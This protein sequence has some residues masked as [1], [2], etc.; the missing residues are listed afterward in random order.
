MRD[1]L[2]N[3]A[4]F[5][6]EELDAILSEGHRK[7]ATAKELVFQAGNTF[8][9][10]WFI[11]SGMMRAFRIIDG[12]DYTFFFFTK[13]NFAVDYHSFLT[14]TPS[15]LFFEV[16]ADIEYMEFSRDTIFSLYD[17][18]PRF[19]R[20]GRIM[21]EQAFV[22][23]TER[24]RQLQGESL[25]V[26]YQKL[27]AQDPELFQTIPQHHIASYLSVRPQSLSRIRAKLSGKKY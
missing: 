7:T 13:Q 12:K 22:S 21:A 1:F 5:T 8:N 26:R 18:H 15:P 10:I 20:V 14:K 2:C 6:E 3:L 24:F 25:E 17:I 9:K 11:E 16:I 27:L 23:A 19:E 4:S